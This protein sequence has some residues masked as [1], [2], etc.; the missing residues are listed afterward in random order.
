M[1]APAWSSATVAT[2]GGAGARAISRSR[3]SRLRRRRTGARFD[4]LGSGRSKPRP[5]RVQTPADHLHRPRF[6]EQETD[7][8]ATR[9]TPPTRGH[10]RILEE[11]QQVE[12]S[13]TAPDIRV[14]EI[15][16]GH[17]ARPQ[18]HGASATPAI[19]TT[20]RPMRSTL[21]Y[22]PR[23]GVAG[24]YLDPL[25]RIRLSDHAG[26]AAQDA[27][28]D[29]AIARSRPRTTPGRGHRGADICT[30]PTCSI[31]ATGTTSSTCCASCRTRLTKDAS[32]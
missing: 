2:W 30:P 4:A 25:I 6:Y 11:L 7:F 31:T 13:Q 20:P 1:H 32:R 23:A 28:G 3:S 29:G 19:P 22:V 18:R 21:R 26:A 27:P 10:R 24:S 5:R 8:I 9:K 12:I 17:P 14:R 15:E 16:L